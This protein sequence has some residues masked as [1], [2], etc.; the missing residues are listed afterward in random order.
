MDIPKHS[1]VQ[2]VRNKNNN[3][4]GVII[5]LKSKNGFNIGYSLCN[6]KDKFDKNMAFKIAI[7][8][9][10]LDSCWWQ[11][12]SMKKNIPYK[13][14]KMIPSFADR[15]KKYYKLTTMG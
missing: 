9:A 12:C 7:G 11:L 6:N 2:Y 8:R 14:K 13:I 1:I 3:L 4:Q 10:E 5:A 15:C